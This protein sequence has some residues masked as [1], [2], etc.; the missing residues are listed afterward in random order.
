MKTRHL[1]LI[2]ILALFCFSRASLRQSTNHAPAA[3]T[4]AAKDEA[5]LNLAARLN[6]RYVFPDKA[7]AAEVAIKAWQAKPEYDSITDPEAFAKALSD[8]VMAVI[9]DKH[10]GVRYVKDPVPPDFDQDKPP[11]PQDLKEF[12]DQ[13]KQINGGFEKVEK[14]P[15][16]IGYIDFRF[17]GQHPV[18][19]KAADAAFAFVQNTDA[20][21]VDM[22]QNGGGSPAMVAYVCSYLFDEPTHLNDIYSRP[23]D[24]TRQFWTLQNLPGARY[25]GKPVYVLTSNRTFSGAEEFSNNLKTQKRATLVGETT[26]GGAHP[27]GPVRLGNHFLARVPFARAINPITKSNWEG[28][29]VEPDIKVKADDALKT[30]Q[31]EALKKLL[32]DAKT[33]E[34]RDRLKTALAAL[35]G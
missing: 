13:M 30:A 7:K 34:D 28:T 5:V 24:S 9:H 14:L 10:F 19:Y 20:L 12:E 2:V 25:L 3:L 22:R 18:C 6:E 16:N 1:L 33:S 8:Q 15:G 23:D 32:A 17:F 29:G 4:K 11:T 31:S 35:G 26:G 21:I 27:V